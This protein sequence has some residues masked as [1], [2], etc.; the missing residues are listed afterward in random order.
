[1]AIL[2]QIL[3]VWKSKVLYILYFLIIIDI[4]FFIVFLHTMHIASL[5]FS[6]S[7]RLCFEEKLSL[8]TFQDLNN[9]LTKRSEFQE[10]IYCVI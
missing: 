3:L 5:N 10:N 9:L 8:L 4:A 2:L 6:E 1:M 7:F